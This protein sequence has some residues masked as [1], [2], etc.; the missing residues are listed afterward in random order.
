MV[1]VT[2][3]DLTREMKEYYRASAKKPAAVD[4]P[5][6]HFLM[7]DGSGDPSAA[8]FQEACGALYGMSYTLK[9]MLKKASR[10]DFKVMPLEGLWWMKGTRFFNVTKRDEW[11]WRAMIAQP[12]EVTAADVKAA[13]AQPRKKK[14]PAA[15]YLG[16]PK[17][18]APEKLKTIIRQP[19][20]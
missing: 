5:G 18:S 17:R 1:P 13:V 15:I 2:S 9:S 19:V 6:M 12:G 16:D 20:K 14:D 10:P 7:V 4:V 3:V 11:Q 8:E